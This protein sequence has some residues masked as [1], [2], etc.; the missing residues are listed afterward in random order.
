MSNSVSA[1][2]LLQE[3]KQRE[4]RE[5]Q[6]R[7]LPEGEV[8]QVSRKKKG[9]KSGPAS[10]K[11]KPALWVDDEEG[12]GSRQDRLNDLRQARQDDVQG[13]S[14]HL[15]PATMLLLLLKS[16]PKSLPLVFTGTRLA[17]CVV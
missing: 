5:Q 14:C 1:E 8:Q 6:A 15:T 3:L 17:N 10:K 4:A 12:V 7:G 13:Q 9:N 2:E 16:A 11:T